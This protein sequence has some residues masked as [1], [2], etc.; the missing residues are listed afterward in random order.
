MTDTW[1][2]WLAQ[3]PPDTA[4]RAQELLRT[5]TDV[6][7]PD[8]AGW[9]RSEIDENIPQAARYR[10]LHQLWPRMI[11][12]WHGGIGSIPAARRALEAGADHEDLVRLARAVAYETVFAMLVYLDDDQP[13]A[14]AEA[15]PS[16]WLGEVDPAG[17]LTGR[18]VQGLYE[19]L[20]TSDPSGSDGQD[21][22][23]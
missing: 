22:D 18:P 4:H 17:I 1:Q 2:D 3:L 11:D 12:V 15:L 14:S 7:C 20:L 8:P 5:L 6:G 9:V 19:D 10:F 13:G 16:W 23:S 21:L